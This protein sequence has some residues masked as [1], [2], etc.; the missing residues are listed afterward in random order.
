MSTPMWEMNGILDRLN[1]YPIPG[2][3]GEARERERE[4]V[5]PRPVR[6]YAG[7]LAAA[8]DV[9]GHRYEPAQEAEVAQ[10]TP[11]EEP[12]WAQSPIQSVADQDYDDE[13]YAEEYDEEHDEDGEDYQDG[14]DYQEDQD[15]QRVTSQPEHELQ[16]HPFLD[17]ADAAA[18]R[19]DRDAPPLA[20]LLA[21]T[22]LPYGSPTPQPNPPAA[23]LYGPPIPQP[24]Q[25]PSP[26]SPPKR[27][28]STTSSRPT[29]KPR[30]LP[31]PHAHLRLLTPESLAGLDSLAGL[32]SAAHRSIGE[33]AMAVS[34]GSGVTPA[35][36]QSFVEFAD[37]DWRSA[38]SSDLLAEFE[39]DDECSDGEGEGEGV[40]PG[41]SAS[42]VGQARQMS[43]RGGEE[44]V[45]PELWR[46]RYF[47][48]APAHFP[49]PSFNAA[50]ARNPA[51]A[52]DPA[53]TP[54]PF[55]AHPLS[56][57]PSHPAPAPASASA[58]ATPP[59][60]GQLRTPTTARLSRAPFWVRHLWSWNDYFDAEACALH[61]SLQRA[62]ARWA[63][64]VAEQA[65]VGMDVRE[66]EAVAFARGRYAQAVEMADSMLD[67][68]VWLTAGQV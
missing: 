62:E 4:I 34:V 40:S 56:L 6:V 39:S 26:P 36:P 24:A 11:A 31:F 16:L 64:H 15:D 50:P 2:Q 65:A 28:A 7:S 14:Q 32:E 49:P 37:P 59:L 27:P 8:L 53:P 61:Q 67:F 10:L 44:V 33:W 12:G 3:E 30:L 66:V 29:K 43:E 46:E 57:Y 58:S 54:T 18:E 38:T 51:P 60:P 25:N 19:V 17:D 41:E 23:V 48:P 35:P 47:A 45:S 63:A 20:D 68:V 21:P 55:P 52:L 13:E 22:V 1:R 9:V 42:Q 5:Q